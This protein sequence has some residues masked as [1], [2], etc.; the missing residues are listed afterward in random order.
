[1]QADL[2]RSIYALIHIAPDMAAA[3]YA[4]LEVARSVAQRC[5]G[6]ARAVL[7]GEAH[8]ATERAKALGLDDVWVIPHT[9]PE[10]LQAHQIAGMFADALS[11][12]QAGQYTRDSLFLVAA[13]SVGEE[14]AGRLAARLRAVPLGK[15]KHFAFDP[16]GRMSVQRSAFGGRLEMTLDCNHGPFLAAVRNSDEDTGRGTPDVVTPGVATP[17]A[18]D[19]VVHQLARQAAPRPPYAMVAQPS[20]EQHASLEGAKLVVSGGRGMGN[21]TGFATLYELAEKLGAAVGGSL[22]AID[23]G[24]A[25]VARQVGQS[26]KYVSPEIYLAVGISGTPQHMAGIDPHTKIVAINKDPDADIFKSAHIGV[27]ADWQELLPSLTQE[28]DKASH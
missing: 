12:A 1:M 27:V 7:I 10:P 24:W 14:V 13:G 8:D 21:E 19:T 9:T 25:P 22:P 26:G 17:N 11:S 20:A 16:A 4:P 15:C 18:A 6:S 28:L 3:D 23:A 2:P 5:Q